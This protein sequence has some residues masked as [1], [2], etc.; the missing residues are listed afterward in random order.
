[1]FG[2]FD[3]AMRG[4]ITNL[5]EISDEF[6]AR[7]RATGNEI[8][9]ERMLRHYLDPSQ[10]RHVRN[11]VMNVVFG[12]QE[13][14]RQ[15]ERGGGLRLDWTIQ[16]L[17]TLPQ[18]T[19]LAPI[20]DNEH[21]IE[22]RIRPKRTPWDPGCRHGCPA[23]L[24]PDLDYKWESPPHVVDVHE[25]DME[26]IGDLTVGV[27]RWIAAY[28][29]T[30]MGIKKAF[31]T[32]SSAEDM[33]GVLDINPNEATDDAIKAAHALLRERPM[34]QENSDAIPG[35]CAPDEFYL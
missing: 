34:I 22:Y 10:S 31:D 11:F 26:P 25:R 7:L 16:E 18:E 19:L 32:I 12:R 4:T 15:W 5:N 27:R 29:G 3:P 1:M 17:A 23:V 2:Q 6:L 13:D 8:E 33:F 14:H 21:A 30:L 9:S 28:L 24:R 35:F 20:R